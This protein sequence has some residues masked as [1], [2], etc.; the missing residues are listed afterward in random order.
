MT[1]WQ[2]DAVTAAWWEATAARRLLLQAC[3]RCTAVQHPPR[4]VCIGCASS[5]L[6]WREASGAGIIDSFTVVARQVRAEIEPPYIVA[7]IRLAEGPLLLTNVVD[8]DPSSVVC[9]QPVRLVWR[10]EAGGRQYPTFTP[11]EPGVN[12]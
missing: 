10:L 12:R 4:A 7:R 1:V 8:A 5:N 9:D 11:T 2:H 3:E 6:G